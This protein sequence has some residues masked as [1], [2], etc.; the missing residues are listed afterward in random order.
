MIVKFK[1]FVNGPYMEFPPFSNNSTTERWKVNISDKEFISQTVNDVVLEDMDIK[2]EMVTLTAEEATTL[3]QASGLP[4]MV[5]E[6][7]D[8][9]DDATVIQKYEWKDSTAF[10][11]EFT[12]DERCKF[13]NYKPYLDRMTA[14][15]DGT[16][17]DADAKFDIEMKLN[18]VHYELEKAERNGR[19][20]WNTDPAL[21]QAT[22]F[23]EMIGF[24]NVGRAKEILRL[25]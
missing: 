13:I 9:V 1:I 22:Y 14:L 4:K 20:F 6:S 17:L 16:A 12:M 19:K 10:L 11:N 7:G 21:Q 3:I 23:L 2:H 8:L 25:P 24:I 5:D 15:P 18:T